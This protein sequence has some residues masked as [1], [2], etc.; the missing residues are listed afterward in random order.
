MWWAFEFL[1]VG[2][3]EI[4]I[5]HFITFHKATPHNIY[6]GEIVRA[7]IRQPP[8]FSF[9]KPFLATGDGEELHE[10][11]LDAADKAPRECA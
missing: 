3:V 1:W 8:G 6:N 2:P 4:V 5:L 9:A 11:G 7:V 10:L